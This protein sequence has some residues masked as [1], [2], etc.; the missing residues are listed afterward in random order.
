MDET[1]ALADNMITKLRENRAEIKGF[2]DSMQ[3]SFAEY[4][5]KVE[6]VERNHP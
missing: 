1:A 2:I 3:K 5:E 4:C 6:E